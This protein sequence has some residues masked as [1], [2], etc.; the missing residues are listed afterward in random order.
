MGSQTKD[1]LLFFTDLE[2]IRVETENDESICIVAN[3]STVDI[4]SRLGNTPRTIKFTNNA[5]FVTSDNKGLDECL[6][7]HRSKTASLIYR[8]ES[9]LG[10]VTLATFFTVVFLGIFI[11]KGLPAISKTIAAQ[12]PE[13]I[14]AETGHGSLELL[15]KFWLKPS[16]L[17]EQKKTEINSLLSP[18][19]VDSAVKEITF[20]RGIGPNALVLPDGTVIVTPALIAI[21]PAAIAF[22]SVVIV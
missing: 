4:S 6:V 15:D 21:G 9:H 8:L 10:L 20:R 16:Q 2:T 3:L 7:K 19:T 11:W 12:L 5:Q 22:L 1:A 14:V 13:R 17:P 18:Y